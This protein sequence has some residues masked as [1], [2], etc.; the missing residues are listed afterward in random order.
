VG[1]ADQQRGDEQWDAGDVGLTVPNRNAI[2]SETFGLHPVGLDDGGDDL[3][4]AGF[5]R[6]RDLQR[7][8]GV[9]QRIL[10]ARTV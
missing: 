9:A 8:V 6:H 2:R 10:R 7:F 1:P 3:V 4:K 5:E